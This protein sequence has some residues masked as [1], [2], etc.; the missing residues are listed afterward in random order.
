MGGAPKE[1]R[2]RG[3]EKRL[4]KRVLL[5][6]PLLLCPLKVFRTFQMF[7]RAK[8]KGAEKKRTLQKHPFGQTVSPHDAFAAP[9]THSE[10]RGEKKSTQTFFCTKFFDNPAGHGT[11]APKLVDVR[12]KKVCFSCGPGGGEKLVDPW[13]SGRKGQGCPREIRTKKPM[14]VW[15][16]FKGQHD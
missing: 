3:A 15:R 5:E 13:A 16:K 4:S 8:L 12:A 7:L 1:R 14:F 9:F 2:R 10:F 11:S 6:S